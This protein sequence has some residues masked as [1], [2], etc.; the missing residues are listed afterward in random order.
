MTCSAPAARPE[1][2]SALSGDQRRRFE[3]EAVPY[4]SQMLPAALRLTRDRGDAEDLIQETFA[5]AYQKFYLFSPGTNLRAWLHKIMYHSFYNGCRRRRSGP[6]ETPVA[7]IGDDSGTPPPWASADSR[8]AEE[9]ALENLVCS[10]ALRALADLPEHFRAVVFL[11]D[12]HG[13]RYQEI[14]QIMAIPLGTVMSRIHRG[15]CLLR[16]RLRASSG[17][18]PPSTGVLGGG[19]ASPGTCT[20]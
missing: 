6:V 2:A 8:P 4:M 9:V 16:A 18:Q 10:P 13:Y 17:R 5:R 11:A 19:I 7:S 12:V 20:S 14:A 3:S 15:R 1:S